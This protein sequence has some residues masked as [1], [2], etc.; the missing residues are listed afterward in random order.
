M[1]GVRVRWQGNLSQ[2]LEKT[3]K[4]AIPYAIRN[5]L[6]AMAFEGRRLWQQ[7]MKSEFV[8]R[9]DFTTRR[10]MVEKARLG[11]PETMQAVVMHPS[12][13]LVKQEY[14]GHE[15]H[16]VPTGIATADGRGANPRQKLVRR[17]FKVGAID[18]PNRPHMANRRQRNAAAVRMAAA[19]GRKFVHLD[20][21]TRKGLFLLRGGRR[22]PR[23][24][25]LWDT[26]SKSHRVPASPTLGPA[27]KRL[28]SVADR[29]MA[30][31]FIGQ[32]KHHKV[33]GY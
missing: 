16:S 32:L 4:R 22:N 31:A 26:T 5:G 33:F 28:E 8:L 24:E 19:K 1:I 17:P 21:P 13:F 9:N 14:G 29:L 12:G 2:H 20:L 27:M 23:V 25:M 11:Q 15:Q 7:E 3:A 18:L 10:V 6:N 30:Q